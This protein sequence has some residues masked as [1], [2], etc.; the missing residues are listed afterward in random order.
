[1][2]AK[3]D[4]RLASALAKVHQKT[5]GRTKEDYPYIQRSAEFNKGKHFSPQ[6]EFKKGRASPRSLERILTKERLN[7]LYSEGMSLAEIARYLGYSRCTILRW[8]KRHDLKL[9]SHSETMR[10][11]LRLHGRHLL[12][13][14]PS[15]PEKRLIQIMASYGLP[16]RYTGNGAVWFDGYNPD[17]INTDGA[18]G[19]IEFFGDYWHTG[20]AK[21]IKAWEG[22]RA[23]HFAK[24]GFRLL[25]IWQNELND[26]KGV[27]K[28]IKR[29]TKE[30]GRSH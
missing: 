29:F 11:S 22:D 30:L 15:N 16:Y 28:K 8:A 14:K 7:Q 17:F 5:R 3:D 4:A 24:Y 6:T 26:E 1:M 27:V 23:Y 21:T 18:K 2:K 19:I 25:V 9:R 20:G 13:K 10:M 12:G